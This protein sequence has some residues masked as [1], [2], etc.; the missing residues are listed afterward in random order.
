MDEAVAAEADSDVAQALPVRVA[1]EDE[2]ARFPPAV[3][4]PLA[5]LPLLGDRLGE[6]LPSFRFTT[7]IVRP[8]QSNLFFG[9]LPA[10][11][12]RSPSN[13][14]AKRAT[15][16]PLARFADASPESSTGVIAAASRIVRR[17][18]GGGTMP[19]PSAPLSAG[20]PRLAPFP[21]V[22]SN[23]RPRGAA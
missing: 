3:L 22:E 23:H 1:D 21:G 13:P 2:V 12:E 6:S 19:L 17:V 8:E 15:A 10:A 7:N 20:V 9:V 5:E 14:R 4:A 11:T 18:G 16:S